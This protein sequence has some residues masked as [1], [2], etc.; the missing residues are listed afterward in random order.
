MVKYLF[1]TERLSIQVHPANDLAAS[2]FAA[3]EAAGIALSDTSR[4]YKDP[5][6]K[7]E[8]LLALTPVEALCGSGTDGLGFFRS[9][10]ASLT[11]S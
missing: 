9:A 4:D 2:G 1:T 3:E 8:L 5:H 10:L 7:P 11:T 6:H